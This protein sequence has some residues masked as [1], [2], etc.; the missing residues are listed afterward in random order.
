MAACGPLAT[1]PG[2]VRAL[3]AIVRL[4]ADAISA[5]VARRARNVMRALLWPMLRLMALG[6][7]ACEPQLLNDLRLVELQET[8]FASNA[9][10]VGEVGLHQAGCGRN[11]KPWAPASFMSSIASRPELTFRG[12]TSPSTR[13]PRVSASAG[14]R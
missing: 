5:R 7:E 13:H 8:C 6:S 3:P 4:R 2:M 14:R 10:I 12:I 9:R 11:R 1:A